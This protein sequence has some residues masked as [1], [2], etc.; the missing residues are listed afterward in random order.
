MEW[1]SLVAI[2][3]L[4][5]LRDKRRSGSPVPERR[6]SMDTTSLLLLFSSSESGEAGN[7]ARI[8]RSFINRLPVV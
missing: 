7:L 5:V 6:L 3:A 1:L 4:A 2:L 8:Q